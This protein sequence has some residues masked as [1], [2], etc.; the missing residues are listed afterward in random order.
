MAARFGER[1]MRQTADYELGYLLG[2]NLLVL[3]KSL[4]F[5][6]RMAL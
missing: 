5:N 3:A 6:L 1:K 4:D 2:G